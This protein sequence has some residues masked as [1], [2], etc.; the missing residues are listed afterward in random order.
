MSTTKHDPTPQPPPVDPR[1]LPQSINEPH[2]SQ[3]QK[4]ADKS[5]KDHDEEEHKKRK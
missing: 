2:G 1:D 5:Q 4:P 3:T